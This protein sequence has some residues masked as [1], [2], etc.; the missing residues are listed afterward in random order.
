MKIT[1]DVDGQR[2]KERVAGQL[3]SY[4]ITESG[5]Q[6]RKTEVLKYDRRG[7]SVAGSGRKKGKKVPIPLYVTEERKNALT[8]EASRLGVSISILINLKLNELER[9]LD[10]ESRKLDT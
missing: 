6:V 7:G 3:H 9:L 4:Y 2:V 8:E 1:Y 5:A 10:I